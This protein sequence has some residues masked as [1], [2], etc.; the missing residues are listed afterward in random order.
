M[1]VQSRNQ[2]SILTYSERKGLEGQLGNG[3]LGIRPADVGTGGQWYQSP[4]ELPLDPVQLAAK[5]ARIRRELEEG[6]PQD[7]TRAHK[8]KRD[9]EIRLLE[10]ELRKDVIPRD[11][12]YMKRADST[13]YS[14]VV[15]ELAGQ[16]TNPR[17]RT[18]ED[19]LKNLLR[20]REFDDPNAGKIAYLREEKEIKV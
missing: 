13:D 18:V 4:H 1:R 11:Y 3:P 17:R 8:V 6:S 2:R 5:Q 12:Y 20:E 9:K 14:K 10:E 7:N 19:R 16:M 15:K